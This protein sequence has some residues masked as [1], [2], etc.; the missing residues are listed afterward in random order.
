VFRDIE[1]GWFVRR[2]GLRN[3]RVGGNDEVELA[4]ALAAEYWDRGLAT[5]MAQAI[6]KLAFERLGLTNVVCFTLPTNRA[7]RRVM[8]KVG[9]DYEREVTHVGS[10][11]VLYR[12]TA[13][14]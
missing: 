14:G 12:I 9:F 2:A 1:N 5:E 6:L 7:S 8:E 4:Y 10:P 3:T 11:H 13:A